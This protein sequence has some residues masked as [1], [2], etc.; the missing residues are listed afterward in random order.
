MRPSDSIRKFS[1]NPALQTGS[2]QSEPRV[3]VLLAVGF[4]LMIFLLGT[5]GVIGFR[6][7]LSIRERVSKLTENHFR[8]VVLIDEVQRVQSS[9]GSVLYRLATGAAIQDS[10]QLEKR[11]DSIEKAFQ[12]LFSSIPGDD[13]DIRLWNEVKSAS[14]EATREA[15]RA[16]SERP[17]SRPDLTRLMSARER[18]LSST[19]A[20]IRANHQ[21]AEAARR[22][23]EEIT[24][25]QLREDVTLLTSCLLLALLCAWTVL[26]TASKLHARITE[27]ARELGKVSW[28]L[29]ERQEILARRLSHELHDELGQSLTALKTN[30]A[31]LPARDA[32][33]PKW[34]EDCSQLLRDSIRSAHEISQLLRPTILDDFGLDSALR[35]LCERFEE[36]NR[37]EVVY[38]SNCSGRL[39]LQSE[40][41]LFRIAQ[42]ALTNVAKHARATRV[43]MSLSREGNQL[44][45]RVADNGVGFVPGGNGSS[46]QFGLT[47]MRARARSLGGAA[48]ID[49]VPGHGTEVQVVFPWRETADEKEDPNPAG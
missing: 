4:G 9:F 26:S 11:V 28:H 43:E 29:M 41:H 16:L 30:F 44:C 10:A 12:D 48:S 38:Q 46:Q 23:I 40:T 19:S 33:D 45:F 1:R 31:R 27:H 5:D 25:A 32:V 35:W 20:L 22:Q 8:N 42:E 3:S 21:R 37:I 15:D 17:L 6:S 34:M 7:I 36:R 18:L 14:A 47:G 49:S 2:A 39:D 13:P 24:T